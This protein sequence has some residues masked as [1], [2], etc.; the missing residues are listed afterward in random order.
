MEE[1][2]AGSIYT[3][4][5]D[6]GGLT[7]YSWKINGLTHLILMEELWAGSIHTY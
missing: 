4:G 2:W 5:K 6:I 1:L 7:L 3:H